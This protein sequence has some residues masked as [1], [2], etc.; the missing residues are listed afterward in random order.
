MEKFNKSTTQITPVASNRSINKPNGITPTST[1]PRP[2]LAHI[3][4]VTT[5]PRALQFNNI[6]TQAVA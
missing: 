3:N 4:M 5:T 1:V 6:S 2:A